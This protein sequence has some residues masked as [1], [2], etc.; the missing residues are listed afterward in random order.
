MLADP[1]HRIIFQE[2]VQHVQRLPRCTGDRPRAVYGV[3]VRQVRVDGDRT[4]VV[5]EVARIE[6]RQQRIGLDAK[7]LPIGGRGGPFPPDGT[8]IQ[9]VMIVDQGCVGRLQ[10]LLTQPP[11]AHLLEHVHRDAFGTVPHGRDAE[12]RAVRDQRG[13][14][15]RGQM[16][17]AGLVIPQGLER[18]REAAPRVYLRKHLFDADARQMGLEAPAAVP[19]RGRGCPARLAVLSRDGH[20]GWRQS[21]SAA[22]P[23]RYAAPRHR[24]PAGGARRAAWA[25]LGRAS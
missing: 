19:E 9:A 11:V 7:A 20:P 18:A 15:G 23:R 5:T 16:G 2:S 12:I 8:E 6:R 21:H 24:I 1:Q 25:W 4:V 13:Q 3:L 14:Q 22:S 17:R 10:S